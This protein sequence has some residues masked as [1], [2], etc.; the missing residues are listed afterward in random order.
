MSIP[1]RMSLMQVQA[2]LALSLDLCRIT[3]GIGDD[4]PI[5]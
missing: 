1:P 2:N 4:K 5:S 3:V